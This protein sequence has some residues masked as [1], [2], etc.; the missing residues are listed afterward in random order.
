VDQTA[1]VWAD[2][3]LWKTDQ[4]VIDWVRALR[5]EDGDPWPER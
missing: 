2:N 1:G 5:A 4:D 3:P